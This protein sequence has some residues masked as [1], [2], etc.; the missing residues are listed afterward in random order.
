MIAFALGPRQSRHRQF[1]WSTGI[2]VRVLCTQRVSLGLVC[3]QHVVHRASMIEV[4][5]GRRGGRES[6]A[7]NS[8]LIRGVPLCPLINAN[9]QQSYSQPGGKRQAHRHPDDKQHLEDRSVASNHV[10]TSPLNTERTS[11]QAT[12]PKLR[13]QAA[14]PKPLRAQAARPQQENRRLQD[15]H[16]GDEQQARVPRW[17]AKSSQ[18]D[19]GAPSSPTEAGTRQTTGPYTVR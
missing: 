2:K 14:S 12:N 13:G 11:N 9:R 8:K 7:D 4:G 19:R 5:R 3:K 16:Q 1:P 6:G 10:S 18:V 15:N 17:K